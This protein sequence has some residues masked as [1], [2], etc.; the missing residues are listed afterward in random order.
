MQKLNQ[1]QEQAKNQRIEHEANL[2]RA[3]EELLGN[4]INDYKSTH[5]KHL[6]IQKNLNEYKRE[7]E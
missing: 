3:Q 4:K 1:S 2:K 7:E 6:Q 5:D